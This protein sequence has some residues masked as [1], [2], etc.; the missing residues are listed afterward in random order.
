MAWCPDVLADKPHPRFDT[1]I[2]SRKVRFIQRCLRYLKYN[3]N[4]TLATSNIWLLK[5]LATLK[6]RDYTNSKYI[7]II[8]LICFH[9]SGT[10]PCCN[11]M[12]VQKMHLSNWMLI[13]NMMVMPVKKIKWTKW[14]GLNSPFP[15]WVAIGG[16][17]QNVN[18]A[19][20][21]M[22]KI[23]MLTIIMGIIWLLIYTHIH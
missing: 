18:G 10:T 14:Y 1:K 16:P 11:L 12:S 4:H 19:V 9:S 15:Y 20:T 5:I 8:H 13:R 7:I 3:H 17:S 22:L 23:M 6:S 2:L 21:P